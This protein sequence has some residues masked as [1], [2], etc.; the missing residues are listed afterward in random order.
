MHSTR[1][2]GFVLARHVRSSERTPTACRPRAAIA[3]TKT[4]ARAW[5]VSSKNE[6]TT[7][8]TIGRNENG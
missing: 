7:I 4:T 1:N 2:F 6:A 5:E 8:K 3:A